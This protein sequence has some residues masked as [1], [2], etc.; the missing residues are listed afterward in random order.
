M[1]TYFTSVIR[2]WL[3]EHA[4]RVWWGHTHKATSARPPKKQGEGDNPAPAQIPA[5]AKAGGGQGTQA[6]QAQL[7][8][9]PAGKA[10]S[11]A[12]VGFSR[13]HAPLDAQGRMK[14]W[15]ASFHM[16]CR[17]AAA[18]CSGSH[19]PIRVKGTHWTV[20]AQILRRGR[21]RTEQVVPPNQ[22]DGKVASLS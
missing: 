12:E 1:G 22:V 4:M 5:A 11:Q 15:D 8:V 18:Q 14:C 16:G 2:Q 17:M 19:E 7:K 21:V 10:S 20:Q 3:R 13:Q 6:P 9:Y